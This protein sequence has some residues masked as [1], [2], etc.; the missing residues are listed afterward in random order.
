MVLIPP[1]RLVQRLVLLLNLVL[2]A[3]HLAINSIPSPPCHSL[4]LPDLAT[5][6]YPLAFHSSLVS[7]TNQ[8]FPNQW[9]FLSSLV[10]LNHNRSDILHSTLSFLHSMQDTLFNLTNKALCHTA[11]ILV[12]TIALLAILISL[13]TTCTTIHRS[14]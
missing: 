9:A 5:T 7:I 8:V 6:L 11:Y 12:L 10:I 3:Q 14:P 4:I 13:P 1:C 2:S